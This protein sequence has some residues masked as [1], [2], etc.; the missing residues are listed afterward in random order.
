MNDIDMR[1]AVGLMERNNKLQETQNVL[2]PLAI[3][4]V[5]KLCMP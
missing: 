5:S 2:I 3:S 1:L 4:F